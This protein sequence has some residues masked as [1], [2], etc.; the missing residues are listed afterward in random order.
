MIEEIK[1]EKDKTPKTTPN[2]PILDVD[3]KNGKKKY[4]KPRKKREIL[5]IKIDKIG[6]NN[7]HKIV[8]TEKPYLEYK[9]LITNKNVGSDFIGNSK[10]FSFIKSGVRIVACICGLF[11]EFELTFILLGF[12]E[13]VGVYEEL[14]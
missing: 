10:K 8:H 2:K 3:H 11:G 4:Y 14:V 6:L 5:D 13:I 12:A 9:K 1:I 7:F